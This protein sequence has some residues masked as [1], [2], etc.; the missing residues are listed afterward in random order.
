M[1]DKTRTQNS[2]KQTSRA[3]AAIPGKSNAAEDGHKPVKMQSD[4]KRNK[5]KDTI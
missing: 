5:W 2:I 1:G 4:L 3:G